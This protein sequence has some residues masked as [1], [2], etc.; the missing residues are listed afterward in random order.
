MP[1][2]IRTP[3]E[4]L[5]EYCDCVEVIEKDV[6]ELINLIS[7]YTCW[8]QRLC[9]TF[10]KSERR[11]VVDLP[12]CIGD[13]DVF[14][15]EP[16]YQPFD[17]DSF[18]FTLVEQ[19]GINE[20]ET[21]ITSYTYSA[22]DGA[23]R[24]ELPLPSCVCRPRCGCETTYK[25][26][27]TYIAGHDNIPECLLPVFCEALV[28]IRDKNKCDCNDCAP[29]DPSEN[30]VQGVINYAS[31]GGLLQEYFL[32]VLTVQYKKQLSLISLC[33]NRRHLWGVV[34]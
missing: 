32:T 15:F 23:F 21:L 30:T 18:T 20:T 29:C 8:T 1:D 31:M 5:T 17:K 6:T 16:F 34:V 11:E 2:P 24:M 14:T 26:I 12:N 7:S 28:W 19:N 22:A 3:L 9:E 10:L 33:Q 4:Q 25:L 13:C 27:V